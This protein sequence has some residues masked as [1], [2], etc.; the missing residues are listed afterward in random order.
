M[1]HHSQ[2]R[3]HHWQVVKKSSEIYFLEQ[4]KKQIATLRQLFC[5]LATPNMNYELLV[6]IVRM[7][8]FNLKPGK[9][10]VV[11]RVIVELL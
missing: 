2:R 10:S 8:E 5:T 3:F 4:H 11:V 9:T 1:F 6:E 7:F